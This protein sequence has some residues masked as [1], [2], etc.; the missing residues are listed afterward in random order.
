MKK[1]IVVLTLAS[2]STFASFSSDLENLGTT[3]RFM[4][5]SFKSCL[6]TSVVVPARLDDCIEKGKELLDKGFSEEMIKELTL[7][8]KEESRE[9]A[10]RLE[11]A[12]VQEQ[13]VEE[14]IRSNF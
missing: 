1:L 11:E 2:A 6:K 10:S 8:A 5:Y 13:R 4:A 3:D 9:A 14:F 7:Q 12:E